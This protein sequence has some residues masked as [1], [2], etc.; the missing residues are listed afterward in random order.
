M[1]FLFLCICSLSRPVEAEHTGSIRAAFFK[2]GQPFRVRVN[3]HRKP[4][5]FLGS[6]YSDNAGQLV[7]NGLPFGEYFLITHPVKELPIQ[8][9]TVNFRLSATDRIRRLP[10]LE[11]FGGV[12]ILPPHEHGFQRKTVSRRRPIRFEW[13]EYPGAEFTL[14]LDRLDGQQK[15]ESSS[16]V[17]N[18]WSFAGTRLKES[19]LAAGYRWWLQIRTPDGI[20]KGRTEDQLFY[21]GASGKLIQLDGRLTYLK[22]PRTYRSAKRKPDL[23]ALTDR[24]YECLE[25][26][27]GNTPFNGER[28]GILYDPNIRSTHS[29]N[30]IHIGSDFWHPERLPW[31][32]ICREMSH[33]F[34]TGSS[35]SLA[36]AILKPESR[37][38]IYRNF[39]EGLAV[40]V[41]IHVG[42][43]CWESK[44]IQG[45]QSL[46]KDMQQRERTS[47]QAGNRHLSEKQKF[48]KIT[49]DILTAFLL[50]V[51]DDHGSEWLKDFFQLFQKDGAGK[52]CKSAE[53][54]MARLHLV[55]AAMET[56]TPES[57]MPH[58]KRYG[59]PV[60]D[61]MF[62][63]FL[64]EWAALAE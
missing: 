57:I 59:F 44:D 51:T 9:S 2:R 15:W 11:C 12:P 4:G 22:L 36:A 27:T 29:G 6:H 42:R 20:W 25:S 39:T 37:I 32:S 19:R 16:M 38:R 10:A 64:S 40:M 41:S 35:P 5:P 28:M 3:L 58:L 14:R 33:N 34:Q 48:A 21:R 53:S 56:A 13:S 49:P 7:I 24:V 55:I 1:S 50:S 31:L 46:I 23:P 52:I 8:W 60:I 61:T 18:R 45:I 47:R 26:L 30:P 63:K 43:R 17:A 54:H 62:K